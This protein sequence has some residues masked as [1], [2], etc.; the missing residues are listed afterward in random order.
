MRST[1]PSSSSTPS[2]R[3]KRALPGGTVVEDPRGMSM[4]HE[5]YGKLN[6]VVK[7]LNEKTKGLLMKERSEFLAAY[8]AHLARYAA[9]AD[10]AGAADAAAA[11]AGC[12]FTGDGASS[13]GRTG[14]RQW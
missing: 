4:V 10:G 3:R 7:N 5:Q 14:Y 12:G 2:S 6:E 9:D 8:R 11:G 13:A 1:H